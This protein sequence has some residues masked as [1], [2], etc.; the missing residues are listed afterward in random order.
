MHLIRGIWWC[1]LFECIL[2]FVEI[3]FVRVFREIT[4]IPHVKLMS[5]RGG[6]GL[7]CPVMSVIS[8]LFLRKMHQPI[9]TLVTFK[10]L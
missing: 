9:K 4:T 3:A 7:L 1:D 5:Q 6:A 2:I 10:N 8:R